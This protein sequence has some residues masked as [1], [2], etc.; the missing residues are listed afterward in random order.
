MLVGLLVL[1]AG[2]NIFML[3]QVSIVQR[4]AGELRQFIVDYQT[5][6]IPVMNKFV[7]ELQGFART[8]PDFAPVLLKYTRQPSR[9]PSLSTPPPLPKPIP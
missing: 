8:H 3:R 9:P 1:T 4:Q 7:T 2:I 5:N 6:Q